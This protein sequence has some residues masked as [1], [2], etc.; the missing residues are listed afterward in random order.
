MSQIKTLPILDIKSFNTFENG[1]MMEGLFF[2]WAASYGIFLIVFQ[3]A[4]FFFEVTKSQSIQLD[5]EKK[6]G[7]IQRTGYYLRKHGT[8]DSVVK[9][10]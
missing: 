2:D 4:K 3:E 1:F 8:K 9:F 10:I 7:T 6:G 5:L